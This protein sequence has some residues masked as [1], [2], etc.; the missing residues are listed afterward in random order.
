MYK[1]AP[2]SKTR[3]SENSNELISETYVEQVM[4]YSYGYFL[5]SYNEWRLAVWAS[6]RFNELNVPIYTSSTL[7]EPASGSLTPLDKSTKIDIDDEVAVQ[8]SKFF[9]SRGG[10]KFIHDYNAMRIFCQ[11]GCFHSSFHVI[12]R[13]VAGV[14]NLFMLACSCE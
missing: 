6:L 14:D 8:K 12:E 1:A 11:L 3:E 2:N 7:I 13:T 10:Y 5:Y 9:L 4:R